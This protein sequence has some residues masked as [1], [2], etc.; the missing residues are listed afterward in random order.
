MPGRKTSVVE[1]LFKSAPADSTF[2]TKRVK[3]IF[4]STIISK[5]GTRYDDT[6]KA[7]WS[8]LCGS[9]E[10]STLARRILSLPSTSAA[11]ERS[12]NQHAN[13]HS[14]KRNRLTNARAAKLL[15]ICHN[16]KFI[17]DDLDESMTM[18]TDS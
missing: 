4:C 15:Y 9:T 2:K 7:W 13:I 8:C 1:S 18:C 6:S 17:K 12:F 3:C 14:L 5:N 16:L 11:V 10:L